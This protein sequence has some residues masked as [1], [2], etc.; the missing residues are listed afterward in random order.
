MII[1]AFAGPNEAV[2]MHELCFPLYRI[3]A[4]CEGRRPIYAP[5]GKDFTFQMDRYVALLKQERPK[6]AFLTTPHN[7]SG[8]L[9]SEQDI[10]LVCESADP[11][12]LVVLDEAYI[13]Y[14]ETLGRAHV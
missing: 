14:S 12:P 3:Y 13:H 1:R 6:I 7:P 10:R 8:R 2:L 5:M 11:R 4:C 9:L